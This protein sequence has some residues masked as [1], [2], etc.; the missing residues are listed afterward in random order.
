MIHLKY[1]IYLRK[2]TYIKDKY[3]CL[4]KKLHD[5]TTD[6]DNWATWNIIIAVLKPE[7]WK[8]IDTSFRKDNDNIGIVDFI[9]VNYNFLLCSKRLPPISA[10]ISMF[11]YYR[12]IFWEIL[13]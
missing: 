12:K 5:H 10:H 9:S 3:K 4:A 11:V 7:E 2:A 8:Q 1:S 6:E 13:C